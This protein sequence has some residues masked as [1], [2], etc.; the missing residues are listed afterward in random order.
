[1]Y[2][3]SPETNSI[4]GNISARSFVHTGDNVMIG[5][6][7][8]QGIEPKRVIVRAIAPELTQ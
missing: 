7:M 4:P 3:L 5:G 6:F 1:M 2:E 8:V